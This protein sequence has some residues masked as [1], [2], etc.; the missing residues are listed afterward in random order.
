MNFSAIQSLFTPCSWHLRRMGYLREQLAIES[1]YRRNR[2]AWDPHLS[3]S[4]QA[5]LDAIARCPQR[6]AALVLGAGLLHDVPLAE[7]AAGFDRVLLADILHLPRNRRRATAL[8]GVTVKCLEFDCTGAVQDLWKAGRAVAIDHA[9]RLFLQASPELP[10]DI[11]KD[12]DLVVSMNLA[13][14]LGNLPAEWL[15]EGRS[16]EENFSLRLRRAAALRHIE[17][18]REFPGVRLL[19]ADQALVIRERD[20]SESEREVILG[21]EDIESPQRTWVWHLAPIPE[22]DSRHHLELEVGMWVFDH[23]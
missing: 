5:V 13:S 3:T 17:W 7:L 6:R 1:R 2:R 15:V 20:G 16:G 21:V 14:Q 9:E 11:V 12:C 4:R 10:G 23:S 22:W 19:V 18:L 8:G